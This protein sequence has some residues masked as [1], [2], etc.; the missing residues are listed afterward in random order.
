MLTLRQRIFLIS[1]ITISIMLVIVLFLVFRSRFAPEDDTTNTENTTTE[2]NVSETGSQEFFKA[3]D[4]QEPVDI[5]ADELLAKQISRIFVER[6]ATYSNQND[7]SHIQDALLL[8]TSSMQ[9]WIRTQVQDKSN[10]YKGVTTR[11]LSSSVTSKTE[12]TATV[13]IAVQ[14]EQ[15]SAEAS[16]IVQRKG[17]VELSKIGEMWFVNGFFWDK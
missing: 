1:G 12:T 7:N 11:V 6:F 4:I 10:Q 8:A 14:Q 13:A 5:D 2:V 15:R 17:R 16:D 9:E 3:P